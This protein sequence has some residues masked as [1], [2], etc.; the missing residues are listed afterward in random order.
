MSLFD[1]IGGEVRLRAVIERFVDRIFE[2]TMI[3]FFFARANRARVKQKEYEHA[4]EH[5]GAGI[6]YTGRPIDAVHAPHPI[7][8]GHFLR[9]LQILRETLEEMGVPSHV[10][11][12]WLAHAKSLRGRVTGDVGSECDG[13]AALQRVQT[14]GVES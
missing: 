1:D 2:D 11:D 10:R 5:L 8:G 13:E 9:R 4:A 3:G 6:E 14:R 12:H 7:Q